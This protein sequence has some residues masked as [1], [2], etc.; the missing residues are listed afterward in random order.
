M[1]KAA[2]KAVA[3][4]VTD[5]PTEPVAESAEDG[6]PLDK[7]ADRP[8]GTVAPTPDGVPQQTVDTD[9][10]RLSHGDDR[11]DSN[12]DR[13]LHEAGHPEAPA[14]AAALPI[15]AS[16]RAM[17]TTK[18]G[19]NA[20]V[21]DLQMAHRLMNERLRPFWGAPLH[22]RDVQISLHAVRMLEDGRTEP[23]IGSA[24][25]EHAPLIEETHTT[26]DEGFMQ[27]ELD[28]PWTTISNDA[29]SRS[30][31]LIDALKSKT[32]VGIV[33]RAQL[34]QS[35]ATPQA[36]AVEVLHLSREDGVRLISD[37]VGLPSAL[38]TAG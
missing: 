5:I 25:W 36:E 2:A 4:A 27:V 21:E 33:V 38:L 32:D 28:V 22:G 7:V 29:T 35:D 20:S 14:H 23:P 9:P 3:T 19:P 6:S 16:R 15:K 30:A 10:E 26:G 1:S 34:L 13:I 31:G 8:A 37:L 24:L 11:G 18:L 12:A 17:T